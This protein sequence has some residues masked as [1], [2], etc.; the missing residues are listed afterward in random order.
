MYEPL[1]P[2]GAASTDIEWIKSSRSYG[3]GECVELARIGK[4]IAVRDSKNPDG[5]HLMFS[6]A[7]M[8]AFIDG[9]HRRE[10]D[11]LV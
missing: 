1:P 6:R 9:V 10:F 2:A 5:S 3:K 8:A 11:H 4:F 7:E